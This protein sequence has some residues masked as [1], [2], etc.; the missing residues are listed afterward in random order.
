MAWSDCLPFL[1]SFLNNSL[2]YSDGSN[3]PKGESS[4]A[5]SSSN[6]NEEANGGPALITFQEL[7]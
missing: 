4:V 6:Y 5:G 1:K 7:G 2:F 3:S